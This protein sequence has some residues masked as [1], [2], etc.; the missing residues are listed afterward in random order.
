MSKQLKYNLKRAGW[1][2]LLAAGLFAAI[3]WQYLAAQLNFYL[4]PPNPIVI[5]NSETE[6]ER[7]K[8]NMLWIESLGISAPIVYVEE[9][10]EKA[11]QVG[12]QNGVVHYPNTALPGEP[13]NAYIFG[14]SS[15]F[16]TAKG[17]YKT[18]FALLPKIELGSVI[19]ISDQ[20]GRLYKYI[21]KEKFVSQPNNLQVLNQDLSIKQL[22]LQTS[23]PI[24]TALRR[25]IV[26]AYLDE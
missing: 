6:P 13:G 3:S 15:D 5:E 19:Q 2:L 16:P 14:H 24:G 12:L 11:F 26:V 10:D 8:E 7:V 18:V 22:S 20:E 21:V 4:K 9:D 1:S 17:N 25:Y 23:Y